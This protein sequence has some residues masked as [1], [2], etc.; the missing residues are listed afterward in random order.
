MKLKD[1]MKVVDCWCVDIVCDY[2]ATHSSNPD[3]PYKSETKT[4]LTKDENRWKEWGN[5]EVVQVSHLDSFNSLFI[6]VKDVK[7]RKVF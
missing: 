2:Y 4:V 1:L 7:P 6:K 5:N 3:E